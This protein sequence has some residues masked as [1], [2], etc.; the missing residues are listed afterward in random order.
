MFGV[1]K[2]VSMSVRLYWKVIS[3]FQVCF[4][5]SGGRLTGSGGNYCGL[6]VF[7]GQ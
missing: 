2:G 6:L 4:Y 3:G 7:S 5:D 1:L